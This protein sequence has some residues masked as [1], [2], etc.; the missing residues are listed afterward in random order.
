MDKVG[1]HIEDLI[2]LKTSQ[3]FINYTYDHV[4]CL[5]DPSS[6]RAK[7]RG[8]HQAFNVREKLVFNEIK[9]TINE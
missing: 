5:N 4:M 7:I 1:D 6:F 9:D 3:D 8:F 2:K